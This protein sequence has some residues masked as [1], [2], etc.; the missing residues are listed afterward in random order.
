MNRRDF[1]RVGVGAGAAFLS[2]TPFAAALPLFR[3]PKLAPVERLYAL[4][5]TT[6][7]FLVYHEDRD[8]ALDAI[9][10]AH[11]LMQLVHGLMSIQDPTSDLSQWNRSAKG[12]SHELHPVT[13]EALDEAVQ[14]VNLTD[15]R[16]DP[17]IGHA[18]ATADNPIRAISQTDRIGQWIPQE[19]KF[20]KTHDEV[21]L[22]LGGSAKGWAVDRAMNLLQKRGIQA[23]LVNAGGDLSVLGHPPGQTGWR[24]GLRDP[25]CPDRLICELQVSNVS[26]ATSGTGG[27]ST[28][29]DP[30]SGLPVDTKG[31][32]TII[33]PT[34]GAADCL[35]TACSVESDMAMLSADSHAVFAAAT[36]PSSLSFSPNFPSDLIVSP[37]VTDN[38]HHCD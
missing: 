34:C 13:V 28:I 18:I 24:I 3:D 19:R 38:N 12:F 4:M 26:V 35:S 37:T 2:T 30:R 9:R 36:S 15:G 32:V 5:G 21:W 27:T 10:E 33:A 20:E 29:V 7:R 25:E 8:D 22:D 14:Y 17:T 16:F 11:A 1:L 23:A 31:T 6:A